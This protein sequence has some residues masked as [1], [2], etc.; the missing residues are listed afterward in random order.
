[1]D[2]GGLLGRFDVVLG[3]SFS[4]GQFIEVLEEGLADTG[5]SG[6]AVCSDCDIISRLQR[7]E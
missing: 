6:T 1:M 2:T 7:G 4:L 5:A 3:V